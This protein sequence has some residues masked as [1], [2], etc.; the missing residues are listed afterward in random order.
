MRAPFHVAAFQTFKQQFGIFDETLA[1]FALIDAEAGILDITKATPEAEDHATTGQMVEHGNLF[2]DTH[3]VMPGQHDDA[4]TEFDLAGTARHIGQELHHVRTHGVIGEM[5]LDAPH[6]I[7]AQRLRHFGQ[8]HFFTIDIG[9]RAEVAGILKNRRVPNVHD[10][11]L[12]VIRGG[13]I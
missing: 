1:A 5:V 2:R 10:S 6:R 13:R 4:G 7:E 12:V 8:T 3:R 9:I 11:P